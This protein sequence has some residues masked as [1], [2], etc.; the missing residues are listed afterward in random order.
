MTDPDLTP[1][2]VER[3]ADRYDKMSTWAGDWKHEAADTLRTLSAELE[4]VKAE[5]RTLIQA[6]KDGGEIQRIAIARAEDAE[7]KLEAAVEFANRIIEQDQRIGGQTANGVYHVDGKFAR[8]ART[9]LASLK[10]D[11][12]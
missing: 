3:L 8:L 1:E 4:A 6:L 5:R 10:G 7:A 11:K 12:P 9:F 2:A